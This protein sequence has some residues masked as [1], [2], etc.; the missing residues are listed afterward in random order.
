M[1]KDTKTPFGLRMPDDLR[2]LLDTAVD[3]SKR[4]LNAEIVARFVSRRDAV[5]WY[6]NLLLIAPN[7]KPAHQELVKLY[8]SLGEDKLAM[9]H[10]NG[11]EQDSK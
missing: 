8:Q 1:G 7:Y 4:S 6:E 3:T 10:A 2:E 5:R 11:L 9:R